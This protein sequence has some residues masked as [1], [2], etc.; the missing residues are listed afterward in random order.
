LASCTNNAQAAKVLPKSALMPHFNFSLFNHI[1]GGFGTYEDIIRPLAAMLEDLGH[2]VSRDN[3]LL[4]PPVTN[5][6]FEGFYNNT[7]W[8][9]QNARR[10]GKRFIIVATEMPTC[11][12]GKSFLFNNYH[13]DYWE[14]R[15]RT[16][17]EALPLVD[18]VW[19]IV[20]GAA[21]FFSQF[22]PCVHD[23]ELGLSNRLATVMN[24]HVT[25]EADFCIFGSEAQRRFE[26]AD[27]LRSA[28]LSVV[29]V[30]HFPF[31]EER[32][33]LASAAKVVLDI[34]MHVWWACVSTSRIVTALHLGRPVISE[35]RGPGA[36]QVERWK[37][38]TKFSQS[39]DTFIG[40]AIAMLPNWADHHKTQVKALERMDAVGILGKAVKASLEYI[41]IGKFDLLQPTGYAPPPELPEGVDP[42][43]LLISYNGHNVVHYN[44]EYFV[45]PHQ[46][47]TIHIN[48][49]ADRFRPGV[50]K[51]SSEQEAKQAIGA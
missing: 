32:N 25:P 43:Y 12:S 23:I 49:V 24:K 27:R 34:K 30:H 48:R 26:I 14:G 40:E 39:E 10:E 46:I 15:S 20:Q 35:P 50:K 36:T 2:T 51:F 8:I 42:P 38:I 5:I 18:A 3:T 33:S 29:A 13:V 41:P 6:L 45:V 11:I 28:G 19:C 22:H 7:L 16:F 47:G 4:P 17:I 1:P 44:G 37:H 31:V 21:K 9:V